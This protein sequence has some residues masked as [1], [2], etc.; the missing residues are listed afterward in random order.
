[1]LVSHA[2]YTKRNSG[3]KRRVSL[4]LSLS[5][6][7]SALEEIEHGR[8]PKSWRNRIC[9][10]SKSNTDRATENETNIPHIGTE[11][12]AKIYNLECPN[13]RKHPN[14]GTRNRWKLGKCGASERGVAKQDFAYGLWDHLDPILG[15]ISGSREPGGRTNDHFSFQNDTIEAIPKSVRKKDAKVSPK[16]NRNDGKTVTKIYGLSLFTKEGGKAPKY[17]IYN[18]KR[19][20]GHLQIHE[21]S[22]KTHTKSRRPKHISKVSKNMSKWYPNGTPNP[23]KNLQPCEVLSPWAPRRRRKMPSEKMTKNRC[24]KSGS[25]PTGPGDP[26]PNPPPHPLLISLRSQWEPSVYLRQL[27]G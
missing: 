1:M 10:S 2:K 11:H 14:I 21:N 12:L 6:S 5:L 27:P 15:P 26:G 25:V 8:K 17:Y 13:C 9:K 4:S 18:I 3:Q 16:G 19:G 22:S 7:A 24:P 23:S 20:S